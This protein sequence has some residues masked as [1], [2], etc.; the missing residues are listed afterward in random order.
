[1]R[2]LIRPDWAGDFTTKRTRH[3]SEKIICKFKTADQW[4]AQA[5]TVVDACRVLEVFL[6][7]NHRWRQLFGGM[8]AEEATRLILLEKD[9]ALLKRLLA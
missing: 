5:Q 3:T 9:N 2:V 6:P 7:T 8:K 4:L 1:L